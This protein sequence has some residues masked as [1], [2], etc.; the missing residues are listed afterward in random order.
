MRLPEF[1]TAFADAISDAV[2]RTYPPLYDAETRRSCGFDLRRLIRKPLG[3]QADAIRA[4]ALSL[5]RQRA[6]IVV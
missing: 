1:L 2:V 4:T 5:Q 6:T 3:A